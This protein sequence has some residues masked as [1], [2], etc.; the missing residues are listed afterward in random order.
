MQTKIEAKRTRS[1]IMQSKMDSSNV[2]RERAKNL[3]DDIYA[4]VK[5]S[6]EDERTIAKEEIKKKITRK[7]Q[8]ERKLQAYLRSDQDKLNFERIWVK[9]ENN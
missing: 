4:S 2:D 1:R 3:M 8:S 7:Y 5:D 9:K 6:Q